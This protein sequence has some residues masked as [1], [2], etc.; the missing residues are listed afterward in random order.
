[1]ITKQEYLNALDV[2]NKYLNQ[3]L[4]ANDYVRYKGGSE[5]VYLTKDREYR[6]TCK[7]FRNKVSIINDIGRRAVINS[8][9]FDIC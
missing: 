1:M 8:I 9:Y 2:I 7:P 6:L 3:S 4:N 5:S